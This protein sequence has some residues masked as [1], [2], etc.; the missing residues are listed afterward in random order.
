MKDVLKGLLVVCLVG[1]VSGIL[2]IIIWRFYFEHKATSQ[3]LYSGGYNVAIGK[4]AAQNLTTG[5][6]NFCIGDGTCPD[7]TTQ[8]CMIDF[9]P[10]GPVYEKMLRNGWQLEAKYEHELVRQHGL[11]CGADNETQLL[12]DLIQLSVQEF[13]YK[14]ERAQMMT[15][16]K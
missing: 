15:G 16:G 13:N 12:L 8:D 3:P 2:F 4:D 14:L 1:L 6:Y 5:S 10:Q 11:H 9:R 7:L